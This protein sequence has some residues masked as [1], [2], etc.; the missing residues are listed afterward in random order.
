M[1][2]IHPETRSAL[3]E[4]LI[5]NVKATEVKDW[6]SFIAGLPDIVPLKIIDTPEGVRFSYSVR[7]AG[8]PEIASY[9]AS[10]DENHL[11]A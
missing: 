3:V 5:T 10:I 11:R 7:E 9:E 1:L 8:K 4:G 2:T 6:K